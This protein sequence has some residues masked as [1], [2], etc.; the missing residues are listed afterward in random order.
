VPE[1]V[2][3]AA[4]PVWP[5]GCRQISSSRQTA[6]GRAQYAFEIGCDRPFRSTDVVRTPWKVDGANFVTNV[7]GAQV[8]RSLSGDADGVTVPVGET[9]AVDRP[10]LEIA[11]DFVVQGIFHIWMG[12]DH[13][14]FVL[15]LCLLARGREL[16]GL[17]TAFTIGHSISLALAFFEVVQ[18]PIPP[19]EASI[20]LSI[21]FMARE[22]LLSRGE[23]AGKGTQ[24]RR[25]AVVSMFGLLH[26]LGF[27]SALR[28]LGVSQGERLPS[29]VFFNVGVE[30]GQLIFVGMVTM[31]MLG[32]KSLSLSQ[33]VRQ[34]ALYGVGIIGAFWT[35]ERVM[36]FVA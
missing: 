33:P 36:S 15:C 12:W 22:A 24:Q 9:A 25:A 8:D 20:A 27:A 16:I 32:L 5:E 13:L 14:S 34:A 19:V 11:R 1:T 6:G 26:G 30:I 3:S 17:V 21:A 29:L 2:Q 7:M 31:I 28:E 23:A 4:P 10:L 35:V 18:V